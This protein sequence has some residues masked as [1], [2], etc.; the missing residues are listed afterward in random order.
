MD[1]ALGPDRPYSLV[2]TV[3]RRRGV[4]CKLIQLDLHLRSGDV[5]F[6]FDDAD[7]LSRFSSALSDLL[8]DVIAPNP[9]DYS[10]VRTRVYSD[11]DNDG[12][13][14]DRYPAQLRLF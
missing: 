10:P 11:A 3:V 4:H 8:V 12:E 5:R 1:L 13:L 6:R 14:P 2:T 9:L 7:T